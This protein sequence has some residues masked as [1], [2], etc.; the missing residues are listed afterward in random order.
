MPIIIRIG[1]NA[2]GIFWALI[3]LLGVMLFTYGLFSTIY[4]FDFDKITLFNTEVISRTSGG[5]VIFIVGLILTGAGYLG[6]RGRIIITT[7]EDTK[8]PLLK[9][10]YTTLFPR[11]GVTYPVISTLSR[12]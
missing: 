1:R 9:K 8:Q 7:S 4:S 11:L 10:S 5:I 3:A 6:I 12:G 2:I